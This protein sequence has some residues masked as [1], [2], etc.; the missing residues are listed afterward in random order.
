MDYEGWNEPD[1][2]ISPSNFFILTLTSS[3]NLSFTVC[4]LPL[5]LQE[6]LGTHENRTE[7]CANKT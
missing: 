6:Y 1:H 2:I 5:A 4:F 7:D 3:K